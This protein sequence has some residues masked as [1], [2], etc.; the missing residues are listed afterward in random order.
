MNRYLS[1]F[2]LFIVF[3][4]S[5][6]ASDETDSLFRAARQYEQDGDMDA[7]KACYRRIGELNRVTQN[8]EVMSLYVSGLTWILNYESEYDSAVAVATDALRLFERTENRE[9]MAVTHHSIGNSYAQKGFYQLA[10]EHYLKALPYYEE[11]NERREIGKIYNALQNVYME[12]DKMPEAVAAGERALELTRGTPS[13]KYALMNLAVNYVY[14]FPHRY[15]DAKRCFDELLELLKAEPDTYMEGLAHLNIGDMYLQQ[16]HWRASEPYFRKALNI[17]TV[18]D[19]SGGVCDAKLALARVALYRNDVSAATQWSDEVL[20]IARKEEMSSVERRALIL[21]GEVSLVERDYRGYS[22]YASAVDSID[23][24]MTG[25][26]VLFATSELQLKYETEQKEAR[27]AALEQER[28]EVMWLSIIGAVVLLLALATFFFL[29]RWA[30]QR[31]HLAEQQIK[32]IATQAALDGEVQE[33]SR[34]ARDLHDGLGSI[35]AA[36]KYNLVDRNKEE[37]ERYDKAIALLDDSMREMRRIAHH[38]MPE[39][40]GQAGLKQS[41][42]DFAD[43]LPNVKFTY[44]GDESRLNPKQEVMVYRMVHEL[45]SNALKHAGA[46]HILVQIVR[47]A[48]SLVLTIQDDGCGFDVAAKSS[49]MGLAN[50]RSRVTAYN[51]HLVIDSKTGIGTEIQIDMPILTP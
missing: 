17:F 18:M 9:A 37:A 50:I 48:E 39:S 12:M 38:L 34:L 11:Q 42:T 41:L 36:A 40:L 3:T 8:E 35:L 4:V 19:F 26:K 2:T 51:G 22:L 44:Y 7:A 21:R 47:D 49:G 1:I 28:R 27:I 13:Y 15:T 30:T 24:V 5:A 45:V 14:I 33:R 16:Q 23:K 46:E 20:G 32:L 29:W 25:E 10:Q 31:K 6:Q 43:T